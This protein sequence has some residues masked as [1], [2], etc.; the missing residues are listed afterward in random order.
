MVCVVFEKRV[1]KQGHFDA[2]ARRRTVSLTINGDLLAKAREAGINVSRTAEAALAEALT[3]H[4][5]ACLRVEI[6]Q[7]LLALKEYVG[8]FEK[9]DTDLGAM[10]RGL[11]AA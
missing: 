8:Y 2:S 5:L 1:M 11:D 10:L 6:E 4:R 9:P 7:D 3:A